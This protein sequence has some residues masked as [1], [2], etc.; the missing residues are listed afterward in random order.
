MIDHRDRQPEPEGVQTRTGS[1]ERDHSVSTS[2]VSSGGVAFGPYLKSNSEAHEEEPGKNHRHSRQQRQDRHHQRHH[3]PHRQTLS[4]M[5]A[6]SSRPLL[7]SSTG[8]SFFSSSC[9]RSTVDAREVRLQGDRIESLRERQSSAMSGASTNANATTV[10][11]GGAGLPGIYHRPPTPYYPNSASSAALS[12]YVEDDENRSITDPPVPFQ[13]SADHEHERNHRHRHLEADTTGTTTTSKS[14]N[15]SK[16]SI[17]KE[18]S[19]PDPFVAKEELKRLREANPGHRA[20]G[21]KLSKRRGLALSRVGKTAN[22][23]ENERGGK[24]EDQPI[25]GNVEQVMQGS[26]IGQIAEA[27]GHLQADEEPIR[28]TNNDE[29]VETTKSDRRRRD[30]AEVIRPL[31][32]GGRRSRPM[33]RQYTSDGLRPSLRGIGKDNSLSSWRIGAGGG[34]NEAHA[35]PTDGHGGAGSGWGIPRRFSMSLKNNKPLPPLPG[36]GGL[37]GL[38][39]GMTRARLWPYPGRSQTMPPPPRF[40]PQHLNCELDFE[41]R[42]PQGPFEVGPAIGIVAG[43]VAPEV[44]SEK[45]GRT[46]STSRFLLSSLRRSL[47]PLV[48]GDRGRS[49][50]PRERALDDN[51]QQGPSSAPDEY[52]RPEPRLV[53]PMP[54]PTNLVQAPTENLNKYL[55]HAVPAKWEKW[56]DPASLALT[57]TDGR[58]AQRPVWSPTGDHV[59]GGKA[60][61]RHGRSGSRSRS[62]T[63]DESTR[64][65]AMVIERLVHGV[66]QVDQQN[67]GIKRSLKVWEPKVGFL[68]EVEACM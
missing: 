13:E 55:R 8:F 57:G 41:P 10:G 47:P 25:C 14:T 58:W 2:A 61:F 18:Y 51:H 22:E 39:G 68:D 54:L 48:T 3:H 29:T 64:G 30:N 59:G 60:R 37:G 33:H 67:Q 17:Q 4:S 24:K 42:G 35:M 53:P 36:I 34:S 23:D 63:G 20:V 56:I 5:S 52:H 49:G 6:S 27:Q 66:I 45:E 44:A 16:P 7:L 11:I 38:V 43:G 32:E 15:A 46:R 19:F 40:L 9:S 65:I 28:E 1:R 62:G 21:N 26:Y 31:A 12:I 50:Y